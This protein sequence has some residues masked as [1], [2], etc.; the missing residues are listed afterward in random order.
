M[1]P[2][3]ALAGLARLQPRWLPGAAAAATT[4]LTVG[5]VLTAAVVVLVMRTLSAEAEA[6]FNRRVD[7]LRLQV[8]QPMRFIERGLLNARAAWVMSG[9]LDAHDLRTYVRA[10][11][12]RGQFPG[13]RGVGV[14]V[15]VTRAGLPAFVET[16]RAHAHPGYAV[17]S[18]GA[19]DLVLIRAVEPEESN[20]AALG[21][22]FM[23]EP[24]RRTAVERAVAT[25]EPTLTAPLRLVQDQ[26]GRNAW[27][28][29]V[30]VYAGSPQ[31]PAQRAQQLLGLVYVAVVI[32]EAIHSAVDLETQGMRLRVFEGRATD[33]DPLYDT[34]PATHEDM[35]MEPLVLTALRTLD[36][37]G[38]ALTL[39]FQTEP[40]L[41]APSGGWVPLAITGAGAAVSG[42]LALIV[43]LALSGKDRALQLARD[44]NSDLD[45]MAGIVERTGGAAFSIDTAGVITWVNAGL[46]ELTGRSQAE[47][48]GQPLR[49]TFA[50]AMSSD[51]LH[52]LRLQLLGEGHCQ[53]EISDQRPDG[54]SWAAH[55]QLQARRDEAGQLLGY[56]GVALD[57]AERKRIQDQ[58]RASEHLVR[59]IAD[60]LPARISY[61]DRELRCHFVNKRFCEVFGRPR[62]EVLGRTLDQ[63]G[64]PEETHRTQTHFLSAL[65]GLPQQYEATS[66]EPDGRR[67]SW[68]VHVIPDLD[69]DGEVNGLIVLASDVSELRAARD[70]ALS[71]S[72]AKSRFLSSMSHEIRT[73]MNAVIGMLRLLQ[74]T[75]L[76]SRQQDY[77]GKA[78]SAAT[79]LLGLLNDILDFSKIEAGRME[80]DCR[81][82]RVDDL[83]RDVGIILAANVGDKDVELVYDVDPRLPQQLVGDDMRLRQI[84]VNLGGNAVKFTESGIVALQLRMLHRSSRG[85]RLELAVEDSGIGMT[86]EEQDRLRGDFMQA[87]GSTARNF[88]GTGLGLGICR[89]LAEMMGGKLMLQSTPGV[90]SRFSMVVTLP[91]ASWDGAPVPPEEPPIDRVLIVDDNLVTRSALAAMARAQGWQPDTAAS[92]EEAVRLVAD[93]LPG[94]RG[95]D[96]ILMDWHMPGIDGWEA[97]RSIRALQDAAAARAPLLMMVTSQGRDMLAQRPT[98]EQALLDG[99]LVKPVTGSM[100]RDAVTQ[101]LSPQPPAAPEPRQVPLAGLRILVV[102]DNDINQEIARELLVS[103]G[104]HVDLAG[105]GEEALRRLSPS[106]W[107]DLVLMD[108]QMPVMDGLAAT[109]LLR[110]DP[111][112]AALP[113]IAMTA[114]VLENDRLDCQAAGMN[115]HVSKPFELDDLVRVILAHVPARAIAVDLA[116]PA[117]A[118][119]QPP[120]PLL[121][122]EAALQR[123]GDAAL[124]QRLMPAFVQ[125]LRQAAQSLPTWLLDSRTDEAVRCAHT[126]K[127]LAATMG[128]PRLSGAAAAAETQ[129][130]QGPGPDAAAA[131]ARMMSAI[132]ETLE[133]LD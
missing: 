78:R 123:L 93:Q 36:V 37:G 131:L 119:V 15:P 95:Y 73:P 13:I 82:F 103:Q 77:V 14:A 11:D 40:R 7:V 22:D 113:I 27:L 5:L 30:P 88:G 6:E 116:V 105:N 100:L 111:V 4:V 128:A 121:D 118:P 92:G 87:S 56:E 101:A 68:Q 19:G 79:S 75:G 35:G 1:T 81:P 85:V 51:H 31:T 53:F 126:L 60:N 84:L 43:W 65:Q 106:H 47:L 89:R 63:L 54:G 48:I 124:L 120:A 122:R 9:H 83:L 108:I 34:R 45:R 72:E 28:M 132:D 109:R 16:E 55:V 90:G 59:A 29:F 20:R 70:M 86:L 61:W 104:A 69:E 102:E 74:G 46:A 76:D 66:T 23:S 39:E 32:E 98:Q 114:N 57:V 71:T 125:N 52:S 38:R 18:A 96:V 64:S 41:V 112:H 8:E 33:G 2:S 24:V 26:A 67:G 21:F 49:D 80:L 58:L 50:R 115:G 110:G 117:P 99:F 25:G 129:L 17:N 127:G 62:H 44:M 107:F 10:R 91:E 97:A 12:S 42:L 130:L 3:R 94:T 133:A